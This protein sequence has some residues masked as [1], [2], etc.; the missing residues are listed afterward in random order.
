MGREV[1]SSVVP[2]KSLLKKDDPPLYYAQAQSSG[3]VDTKEMVRRIEKTCTVTRTDVTA[4][5]VALE[6]TI[7]EGRGW[8]VM[9]LVR[10]RSASTAMDPRRR[11]TITYR[12]SSERKLISVQ[13]EHLPIYCQG[14]VII[15]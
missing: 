14:L 10:S 7:V 11:R 15:A 1:S 4:V 6:N 9:R 12:L 8:S 3:D 5:L 2:R 13:G